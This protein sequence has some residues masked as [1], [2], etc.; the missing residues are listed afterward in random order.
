[1][2]LEKLDLEPGEDILTVVRKHWFILASELAGVV[3]VALLPIVLLNVFL[4]V[5][6]KYGVLTVDTAA[7]APEITFLTTL[8]LLFSVFSGFVV[9]THYFLDLWI[10]TDRRIISVEQVHFFNRN[11][12]IFRLERL[13]DIEFKI[14]GLIATFFNYG[15]ISAQTAGHMEANF[16]STGMPNPDQLQA[17]IQKAMDARLAELNNRPNLSASELAGE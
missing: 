17:T 12:A 5:S 9:W 1:M 3:V 15:T 4:G 16:T 8:W 2:L 14:K 11:V 13:Q 6:G 7:Y 10:V